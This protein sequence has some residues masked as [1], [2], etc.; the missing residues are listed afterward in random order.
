M[1]TSKGYARD[2]PHTYSM[3]TALDVHQAPASRSISPSSDPAIVCS[4]IQARGHCRV[5]FNIGTGPGKIVGKIQFKL[6]TTPRGGVEGMRE[7][8]CACDVRHHSLNFSR[9]CSAQHSAFTV[10]YLVPN[11]SPV[12]H[13]AVPCRTVLFHATLHYT[14]LCCAVLH[15]LFYA[16]PMLCHAVMRCATR[17]TLHCAAPR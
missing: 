13:C 2:S 15:H 6:I 8:C 11:R 12:L 9:V 17:T 1:S 4:P 10:L 7:Y 3:T 14:V 16:V 5:E